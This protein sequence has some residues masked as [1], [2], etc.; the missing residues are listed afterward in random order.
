MCF[1]P[2]VLVLLLLLH[3]PSGASSESG[4]QRRKLDAFTITLRPLTEA[5]TLEEATTVRNAVETVLS[6]FLQYNN[7][8]NNN[9]NSRSG[10]SWPQGTSVTYVGLARVLENTLAEESAVQVTMDGLVYFSDT[11]SDLPDGLAMLQIVQKALTPASLMEALQPFFPTLTSAALDLRSFE[12]LDPTT[13]PT[14]APQEEEDE[15]DTYDDTNTDTDTDVNQEDLIVGIAKGTPSSTST[16]DSGNTGIIVGTAV[17]G[18]AFVLLSVILLSL[19]ARRSKVTHTTTEYQDACWRRTNNDDDEKEDQKGV[20]PSPTKTDSTSHSSQTTPSRR[21]ID[22]ERPQQHPG[23]SGLSRIFT[24]PSNT[25]NTNTASR[26]TTHQMMDD[27]D[28]DTDADASSSSLDF[29]VDDL[30]SEFDM[31]SIVTIQP[32][33]IAVEPVESFQQQRQPY[34]LKKDM[35]QS[36]AYYASSSPSTRNILS[37]YGYTNADT[38]NCALAPTD[39]SAATLAL[40]P[41]QNRFVSPPS[42]LV[43]KLAWWGH[44]RKKPD[45]VQSSDAGDSTTFGG[46]WDPD[47]QSVGGCTTSSDSNPT[48]IHH[49]SSMYSQTHPGFHAATVENKD[50]QTLLQHSLRNESYKMQ[51]LRTP[52]TTSTKL[53]T[54]LGFRSDDEDISSSED[55]YESSIII[56]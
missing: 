55:D 3:L 16:T 1:F 9:S 17:A 46:D 47:D 8:N 25:T 18:L 35:L 28:E 49:P 31:D 24:K 54:K 39:V 56:L 5:L 15:E 42:L 48:T 45:D 34:Y 26:Q 41:R 14:L 27:D 21:M 20:R 36:D 23:A 44:P 19:H 6:T 2:M 38:Y 43:P 30:I 53:T 50:E 22:V 40:K 37:P 29:N 11:S 4:T 10:Y 13:K 7:N 32:H 12:V 51:R 52:T 33:I